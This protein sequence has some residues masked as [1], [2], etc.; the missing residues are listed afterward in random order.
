MRLQ[1]SSEVSPKAGRSHVLLFS[2]TQTKKTVVYSLSMH[3][4]FDNHRAFVWQWNGTTD[5]CS[6]FHHNSRRCEAEY[7]FAGSG[8]N[9][10]DIY[11]PDHDA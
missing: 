3:S 2:D 10:P 8:K 9:V 1:W 5:C 11:G 7:E 6:F 4:V